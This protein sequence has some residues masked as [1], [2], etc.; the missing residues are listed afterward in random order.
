[1]NTTTL[2][3]GEPSTAICVPAVQPT[4]REAFL[5]ALSALDLTQ[6]RAGRTVHFSA[7]DLAKIVGISPADVLEVTEC[8]AD[9]WWHH[10]EP[11]CFY[12]KGDIRRWAGVPCHGNSLEDVMIAFIAKGHEEALAEC[13]YPTEQE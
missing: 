10:D 13:F 8:I 4:D 1:M 3:S 9:Y 7:G 11:K 6:S 12:T 2:T 5:A